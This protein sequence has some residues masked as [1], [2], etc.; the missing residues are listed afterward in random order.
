MTTQEADVPG[1]TPG[2]ERGCGKR[3]EGG[4]YFEVGV[5]DDGQPFETFWQDPPIPWT[6]DTKVGQQIIERDGTAHVV[7]HVGSG[8]YPYPADVLEE[9]RAH[10][11]SRRVS[12]NFSFDRLTPDSRIILVHDRALASSPERVVEHVESTVPDEVTSAMPKP[13]DPDD[14]DHEL[15]QILAAHR[16][17]C[18][19]WRRG[20]DSHVKAPKQSPCTRFWYVDADANTD[21]KAVRTIGDTVYQTTTDTDSD[22]EFE[23]GIIASFPI[24]R[25]SVIDSSDGSHRSTFADIQRDAPVPVVTQAA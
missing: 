5:S 25:I 18:A 7:D 9:M 12:K 6:T 3:V 24:H 14:V 16:D 1:A 19:R 4:A 22:F 8:S 20:D 2:V 10:G 17:R 23:T 15:Q 13:L 21:G 11:L